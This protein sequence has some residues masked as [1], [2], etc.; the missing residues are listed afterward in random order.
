[1]A[2]PLRER[3]P[4]KVN[5]TLRV[6]S[7]RADG[8]HELESLV[9]FAELADV[10]TFDPDAPPDIEVTGPFAAATGPAG[11]NLVLEAARLMRVDRGRFTLEKNI[12]VAAGLGGGSADAAAAL[13]LI[14]RQR[15]TDTDNPRIRDAARRCGADVPVC[16]VP[17]ARIMR[18]IGDVLSPPVSVPA[19]PALLINPGVELATRDVFAAFDETTGSARSIGDV[20]TEL[21]GFVDWLKHYD[22]DL[23]RAAISRV[24]MI[25]DILSV[26]KGEPGCQLARMSGSGATCVGI[27]GSAD[28]M[29]LAADRLQSQHP[30]WWVF[31]TTLR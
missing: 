26:L 20:P 13:R 16:L 2:E 29:R 24:P 6:V 23:T 12:P 30:E 10:V 21:A 27:F 14:A 19:L 7:R 18:G 22:N 17:K 11:E 31:A 15:S 3:A 9:A 8:Y 28:Q 25:A 1:V 5:L 4:A